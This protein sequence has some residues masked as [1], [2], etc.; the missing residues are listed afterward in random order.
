MVVSKLIGGLGNQMFQYAAGRSLAMSRN[1]ELKLDVSG[2]DNYSLHNGYELSLFNIEALIGSNDECSSLQ[3]QSTLYKFFTKKLGLKGKSYFAEKNF[4]FD[5][6][7]FN[8]NGS[9]YIDGYW[10]SYK[11]FESI[12]HQLRAELIPKSPLSGLNLLVS[13]KISEVSAVSLHIRRGDYVSNKVTNKF[14]GCLGVDYYDRAIELINNR[15]SDPYYFVF[16]DDISWAKDN[17]NLKNNVEFVNHNTGK[18]SYEDMR[19]M[20][21]CQ[22][23]IIANSS[24]SWW[25]A[26][27]NPNLDKIVIAPKQWFAVERDTSDLIPSSWIRL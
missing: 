23:H 3:R 18:N 15:V 20:S 26:W 6:E 1:C 22:H 11:Y 14:H 10:Q 25:G 19:L 4:S 16:S 27:L 12:Q 17:L 2:F 8:L 21:L 5:S 13:E 9:V 24:F 7:F